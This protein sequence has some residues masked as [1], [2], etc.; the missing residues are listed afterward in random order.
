MSSIYTI[1][2]WIRLC[3]CAVV[4]EMDL[5]TTSPCNDSATKGKKWKKVTGI[6]SRIAPGFLTSATQFWRSTIPFRRP[7]PITGPRTWSR[8][9]SYRTWMGFPLKIPCTPVSWRM[10]HASVWEVAN[11]KQ[12]SKPRF[13]PFPFMWVTY[14]RVWSYKCI[15]PRVGRI[16]AT[17]RYVREGA[18][19][20]PKYLYFSE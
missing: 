20:G 9:C 4:M 14:L 10:G 12:Y 7:P 15:Q 11:R 8:G 1:S 17:A 18:A 19:R 13:F 3:T 16:L 6:A 5:L 2:P